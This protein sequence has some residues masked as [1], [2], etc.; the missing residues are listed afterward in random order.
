M[1]SEQENYSSS[2]CPE[3]K[4]T[5][6]QKL[7]GLRETLPRNWKKNKTMKSERFEKNVSCLE[8]RT[9]K[10]TKRQNKVC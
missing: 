5:T 1:R 8:V 4:H 9:N 2:C 10:T 6:R 7:G 3:F